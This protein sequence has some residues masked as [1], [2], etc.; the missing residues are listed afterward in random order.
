MDSDTERRD[1]LGRQAAELQQRVEDMSH[2]LQKALWTARLQNGKL[3]R[4]I[5]EQAQ[6]NSEKQGG[7]YKTSDSEGTQQEHVYKDRAKQPWTP[8]YTQ[9]LFTSEQG[10]GGSQ[11]GGRDRQDGHGAGCQGQD[12]AAGQDLGG[13]SRMSR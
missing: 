8:E 11:Q 2:G 6:T 1:L 9:E 3:E 7:D 13:A 5:T 4:L 12:K 10:Q